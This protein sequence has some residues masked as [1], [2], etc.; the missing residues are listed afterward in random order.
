MGRISSKPLTVRRPPSPTVVPAHYAQLYRRLG[1]RER[2]AYLTRLVDQCAA[3]DAEA[4]A[5]NVDAEQV[6]RSA[7]L[8]ICYHDRPLI[9]AAREVHAARLSADARPVAGELAAVAKGQLHVVAARAL[10][11]E[12]DA[13]VHQLD[14]IVQHAVAQISDLAALVDGITDDSTAVRASTKASEAW[15]TMITLCERIETA[16]GLAGSLRLDGFVPDLDEAGTDD[17]KFRDT[18]LVVDY[19]PDRHPV[20]TMIANLG[21]GPCCATADEILAVVSTAST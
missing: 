16:W 8:D 20:R 19:N 3:L 7:V 17:W 21:A 6:R 10:W 2:S 4:T 14:A 9:D 1:L 5:I 12:S 11:N 13:L 15:S 18:R